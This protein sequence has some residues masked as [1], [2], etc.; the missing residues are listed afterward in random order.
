MARIL[1]VNWDSREARCVLASATGGRLRI[2]SAKSVGLVD[3]A[4]GGES[5]TDVSGSLRAV[6]DEMRPSR[7]DVL[8]AV[9]RASVEL[10]NFTLPPAKDSELAG[11]VAMQ[12]LRES[13]TADESSVVDFV[14]LAET[15][16]FTATGAAS[17]R[18]RQVMAAVLSSHQLGRI[19]DTCR[20]AGLKPSRILL[21]PLAAASLFAR[22]VSPEER[23]CLLVNLVSDEAD[24]L[25]L[26]DGRIAFQ[27][28]VRLPEEA[29]EETLVQRLSAEVS[30]TLVVAQQGPLGGSSVERIYVFGGAEEWTAFT[31]QLGAVLN[32]PVSIVD[33]FEITGAP[34]DGSPEH[35]GRFAALVGMILDES[36]GS[37]AVDFLHPRRPPRQADRRQV[38]MGVA[39]AVVLAALAAGYQVW[40]QVASA[41]NRIRGLAAELRQKDDVLKRTAEQSQRIDAIADWQ[42]GE[43]VWLDELRELSLRLPASRDLVLMRMSMTP[44]RSGGGNVEFTGLVRDPLIVARMEQNLRDQFHDVRSK[45]IQERGPGK[46]YSWVF[47]T[48]MSVSGRD[49]Q[50]YLEAQAPPR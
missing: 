45:R 4:E 44:E 5:H 29:A 18:P 22:R 10:L 11:L 37:H 27:R 8:V 32:V 13:Q 6:L 30:R 43:I 35:P 24:L 14:P 20:D 47:E 7:C 39:A 46:G 41:E 50:S 19:V 42:A 31:D 2:L 3:V 17:S 34:D 33:P 40:S 21:R 28:T 48:S 16:D 12:V 9:D 26:V 1:A 49:K 36:Y 15:A 38:V 25:I 23:N